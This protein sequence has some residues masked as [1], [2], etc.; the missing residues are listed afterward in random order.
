V[1]YFF[2]KD[3]SFEDEGKQRNVDTIMKTFRWLYFYF[4]LKYKYVFLFS[5]KKKRPTQVV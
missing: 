5:E 2:I 4:I 1:K 3:L